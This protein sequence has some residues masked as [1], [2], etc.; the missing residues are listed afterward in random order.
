VLIMPGAVYGDN[1]GLIT[2]AMIEPARSQGYASYIADGG[3]HMALVH[4]RDI[5][6][7]Y[8]LAL[9]APAG[10]RYLGVG[11]S[12]VT[13]RQVAEAVS[14]AA[15]AGGTTRSLSLGEARQVWGP[16]ADALGLD[17]QFT[18]RHA[19]DELGWVPRE[20]GVLEY[21]ADSAVPAR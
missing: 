2:A 19:R 15:G 4:R 12:D 7:L 17:Q 18:A 13:M 16:L 11:E 21:Q 3:N 6:R 20:A 5:A 10:S 8:V 9:G 1:A 14:R